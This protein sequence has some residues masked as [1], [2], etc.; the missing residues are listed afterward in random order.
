MRVAI[1]QPYIFPYIGYFQLMNLVDKF[2]LYDDVNYINKGW[3]NRNKILVNNNE[4]LFTLPLIGASQ[5][6]KINDIE[7]A[8][9]GK[10]ENKII[11][12]IGD[13]YRKAPYFKAVFP[14]IE[15]VFLS[16]ESNLS[17]FILAS[18]TKL[19]AYLDIN[20]LLLPS[21]SIYNNAHLKG[22]ERILDI[23]RKELATHYINPIGGMEIYNSTLFESSNIELSFIKSGTVVYK[24]S[25]YEF[26]PWLSII[27]VIM[28]N[29][30]DQTKKLL[31][32]Y[33]LIKQPDSVTL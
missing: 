1:M 16:S 17:V 20:T 4:Y 33:Q 23:C 11:K 15:E 30:I 21:S 32:E 28:F 10:W 24:Q 19:N 9:N 5:N 26:F 3:I 27:D 29:S 13:S 18:L 7:I 6:K 25:G 2:V 8:R 14:I 22:Q 12:T 31:D